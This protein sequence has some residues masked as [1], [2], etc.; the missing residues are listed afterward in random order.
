MGQISVLGTQFRRKENTIK[1]GGGRQ[2]GG[3]GLKPLSHKRHQKKL[4]GPCRGPIFFD[5]PSSSQLDREKHRINYYPYT[6][7]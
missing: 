5:K 2:K 3:G 4:L 7:T 6:K 1:E